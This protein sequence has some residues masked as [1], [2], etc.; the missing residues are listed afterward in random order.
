MTAVCKGVIFVSVALALSMSGAKAQS[1]GGGGFG[2]GH[3]HQQDAAKTAAQK[4]KA[5]E[6][7]YTAALQSL[8]D[9]QYDPWHGVR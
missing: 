5:D 9:K 8:P 7:A 6:K 2:G 4:P 3:K 1:M